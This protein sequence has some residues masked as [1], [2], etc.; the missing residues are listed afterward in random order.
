MKMKL[1]LCGIVCLLVSETYTQGF[2]NNFNGF[3][4]GPQPGNNQNHNSHLVGLLFLF[5]LFFTLCKL[6]VLEF[7]IR[8]IYSLKMKWVM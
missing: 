6:L 1:V 3:G 4:N 8:G 7:H 2:S 5:M